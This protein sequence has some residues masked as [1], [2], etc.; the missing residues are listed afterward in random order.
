DHA[1]DAAAL[2]HAPRH[3]RDLETAGRA[4][5]RDGVLV[6]AAAPERV[7]RALDQAV[8]DEGVEAPGDDGGANARRA[9]LPLHDAHH[10]SPGLRTAVSRWPSRSRRSRSQPRLS[11]VG[12]ASIGTRST[13][14]MP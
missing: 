13:T 12:A 11:V 7:D 1:V 4:V 8:D 14:S 10:F 5:Q 2:D 9:E 3:L 6:G